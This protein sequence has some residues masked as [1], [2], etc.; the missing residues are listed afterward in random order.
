LRI[1]VDS[2]AFIGF[3]LHFSASVRRGFKQIAKKRPGVGLQRYLYAN[4][5]VCLS[6]RVVEYLASGGALSP[7]FARHF[8]NLDGTFIGIT[9]GCILFVTYLVRRKFKPYA[10]TPNLADSYRSPQARRVTRAAF[11][12]LPVLWV[13]AVGIVLHVIRP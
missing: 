8:S 7:S 6:S 5:H 1:G 10:L 13:I 12:A 9:V 11:I 4:Q 3:D 2:C